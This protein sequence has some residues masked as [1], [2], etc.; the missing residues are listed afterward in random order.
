MDTR[1]RCPGASGEGHSLRAA[2][3]EAEIPTVNGRH[4]KSP[5]MKAGSAV[6]LFLVIVKPNFCYWGNLDVRRSILYNIQ[7]VS[8]KAFR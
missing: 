2:D 5:R 3:G 4:V 8:F 1:E 6:N 7:G